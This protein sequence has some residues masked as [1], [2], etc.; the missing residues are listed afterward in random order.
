MAGPIVPGAPEQSVRSTGLPSLNITPSA[1]G[2]DIGAGMARAGQGLAQ[3][4]GQAMDLASQMEETTRANLVL[5]A[6]NGAARQLQ[7]A[8]HDP[9]TGLMNKRGKD[10][11]GGITTFDA[12][13]DDI[14]KAAVK[15]ISDPNAQKAFE[16][17]WQ[18]TVTAHRAQVQNFVAGQ[19]Q[20]FGDETVKAT[21]TT[22]LNDFVTANGDAK[23]EEAALNAGRDAILV[24]RAGLP[25]EAVQQKLRDFRSMARKA[26]VQRLLIDNPAAAADY[27]KAN[28]NDF[29]GSD[30]IDVER[31]LAGPMRKVEIQKKFQAISG[32]SAPAGRL[33]NVMFHAESG[34][35]PRAQS[36]AGAAGI[37][38]VMPGTARELS[39]QLG[40]GKITDAMSDAQ[41]QEALKS[42]PDLSIR[43]GAR[44]MQDQ[45][46]RYGG[47]LEAALVAYN[48]GP[49]NAEKWL[50]AGRD[51]SALPK[52]QETEPYTKKIMAAYLGEGGP[53]V[54]QSR[55]PQPALDLELV[56]RLGTG[57]S[58]EHVFN[59]TPELKQGLVAMFKSAPPDIAKGFGIMSGYRSTKRQAGIIAENIDKYLPGRRAAWEADVAAM[60]P[61]AAG[62][63]WAGQFKASGLSRMI[64][65]PGGSLHQ[66]GNAAD[67]TWNGKRLDAAPKPVRD[68]V[69][70]NA[71][72]FGLTLPMGHEPWHIEPEGARSGKVPSSVAAR[73]AETRGMSSSTVVALGGSPRVPMSSV[74]RADLDDWLT[75]AQAQADTPEEYQRLSS[76]LTAEFN[77]RERAYK[78]QV[79]QATSEAFK[80]VLGGADVTDLP[81][82]LLAEVDG[83]SLERLYKLQESVAKRG[84]AKLNP[85]KWY[86]FNRLS[87]D[88]LRDVDVVA[89]YGAD[90]DKEHLDKAIAM[91]RAVR[92]GG[93][94]AADELAGLRTRSQIADRALQIMGLDP[95]R[96]QKDAE[97]AGLFETRL[98]AELARET[99]ATGKPVPAPRIQEIVDRLLIEGKNASW[100]M[101][102]FRGRLFEAKPE[103]MQN[104]SAAASPA[105][106]PRPA[107]ETIGERFARFNGRPLD[108]ERE[109]VPLYNAALQAWA[110]GTAPVPDAG[111]PAGKGFRDMLQ[112]VYRRPATETELSEHWNKYLARLIAPR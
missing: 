54:S 60:G 14:Y 59:M 2:A 111:T 74:S 79:K 62:E 93:A 21:L 17:R 106:I 42:D 98:D 109:A 75:Q 71:A 13:A 36:P 73:P 31:S 45:L 46:T 66:H 72:R 41:V 83:Q 89:Q 64:G 102:D 4:G 70:A 23:A 37:S 76:M 26:Q 24:N 104:F 53:A 107:L 27:Y 87:A 38:Q 35:N 92:E 16:R 91:Q 7:T 57:K 30:L 68:W 97:K 51:Y 78:D 15:G 28:K 85:E 95:N 11:L 94:K 80:A 22:A 40:D 105:D 25:D 67:L 48:A 100:G 18:Q 56:P 77:K 19:T 84:E 99:R 5:D 12:Q 103:D 43:Y 96:N 50:K 32:V 58:P 86:E 110:S 39:K 69:Q 8:L 90:L 20:T 3:A 108:V 1:F 81:A 44:Y 47:D 61:I 55:I 63:K 9:Q 112:S 33:L 65:K 52:P 10:A 34:H 88:E 82:D 29:N 6:Y 101:S 49:A